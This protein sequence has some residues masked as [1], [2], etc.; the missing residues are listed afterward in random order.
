[1]R[2]YVPLETQGDLNIFPPTVRI[3]PGTEHVRQ[4]LQRV[5]FSSRFWYDE[6]YTGEDTDPG[7][8]CRGL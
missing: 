4:G 6:A 2:G 8:L 1:M 3:P 5:V 7:E